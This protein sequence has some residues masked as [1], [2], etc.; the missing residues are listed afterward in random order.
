MVGFRQISDPART[1]IAELELMRA[2]R[3]SASAGKDGGLT[4]EESI[5]PPVARPSV[6]SGAQRDGCSPTQ[7][8]IGRDR[9]WKRTGAEA[10]AEF[11]REERQTSD[12]AETGIANRHRMV[13]VLRLASSR[14]EPTQSPNVLPTRRVGSHLVLVSHG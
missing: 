10:P 11:N 4:G 14:C 12:E 7:P 8:V 9:Q 5:S 3:E 6:K 2:A 13:T 1:V